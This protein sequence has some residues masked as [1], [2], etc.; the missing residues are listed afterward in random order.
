MASGS[1]YFNDIERVKATGVMTGCAERRFC[2]DE[3]VSRAELAVVL[4]RVDDSAVDLSQAERFSDVPTNFWAYSAIREI[5]ARG[6]TVGCGEG[7]YCPNTN[8]SRANVA[9]YIRRAMGQN[10]ANPSTAT[11]ADTPRNYWAFGSIERLYSLGVVNGCSTS[12][13]NFCPSDEVTRAQLASMLVR[14]FDL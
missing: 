8:A 11:F 7:K 12:P 1:T 9:V 3:P 2:P 5:S 4:A 10:N 14:A 6:I 13:R